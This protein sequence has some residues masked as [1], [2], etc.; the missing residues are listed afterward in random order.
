MHKLRAGEGQDNLYWASPVSPLLCNR[1]GTM[2]SITLCLK[3]FYILVKLQSFSNAKV[4]TKDFVNSNC[5]NGD[6]KINSD[7]RA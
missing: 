2:Q 3:N 4:L 7:F 1:R 6:T 5:K